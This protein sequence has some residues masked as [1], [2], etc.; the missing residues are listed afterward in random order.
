MG[1][2][3]RAGPSGKVKIFQ[4][5][6]YKRK[7]CRHECSRSVSNVIRL[8]RNSPTTSPLWSQRLLCVAP[9]LSSRSFEHHVGTSGRVRVVDDETRFVATPASRPVMPYPR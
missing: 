3:R 4:P 1:L 2:S 6:R 5:R 7:P 9:C 8:R